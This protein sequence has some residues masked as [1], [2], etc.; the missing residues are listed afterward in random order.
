[1]GNIY[2]H[3]GTEVSS[4]EIDRGSLCIMERQ[5]W[6]RNYRKFRFFQHF[7]LLFPYFLLVY[8][9][10]TLNHAVIILYIF[11]IIILIYYTIGEIIVYY[12]RV[13]SNVIAG[14]YQNGIQM[15]GMP[16]YYHKRFIPFT[17]IDSVKQETILGYKRLRIGISNNT[18][19]F[20]LPNMFI[21]SSGISY[22]ED[23]IS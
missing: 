19:P 13:S 4:D 9:V 12:D 17:E 5:E 2:F 11:L 21:T 20:F 3:N 14:I 15:M 7:L 22:I 18:R 1:M 10:I 6:I 23:S 8:V 16:Y